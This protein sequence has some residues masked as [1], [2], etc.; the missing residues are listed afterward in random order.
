MGRNVTG[1]FQ[2]AKIEEDTGRA[3]FTFCGIAP[4][5]LARDKSYALRNLE[6]KKS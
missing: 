6:L 3:Y 4:E 2:N 1:Q 5:L